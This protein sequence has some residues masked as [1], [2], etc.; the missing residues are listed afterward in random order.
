VGVSVVNALSRHL[1][2]EVAR[3]R[4]LYRQEFS[5]GLATTALV[6]HGAAPNRRG[7]TI[8]FAPDPQIFGDELKLDPDRVYRL[9]RS[10]AYLFAGVEVRWRCAAELLGP[11]SA[12]PAQ[13]SMVFPGG[14][15]DY[16]RER[17]DG[18]DLVGGRPF[19]GTARLADDGSRLDWAIAWPD[20]GSGF[21]QSYC[22]TIPTPLGGTH[23]SGLRMG[24][25]RGLR[26]FADLTGQKRA[27]VITADDVMASGAV[28]LSLFLP[29]PQFQ[30]QTKERLTSTQATRLVESA[31][32]DNFEHWLS[33]DPAA[34]STLLA[35]ILDTA[36]ERIRRRS[37]RETERK[38]A[39]RRLRLPGKLADCA[40]AGS[41]GTEIFLVE[42]DSA[43][44]TA[45]TARQRETQAILPLRGKIMNV[46][47]ASAEK[48]A[49]N[50]E[51]GNLALALG[52]GTRGQCDPARLRYERVI[53]MTDADVDGAHIAS[54]LITYFHRE[55]RPI[56]RDGHLF[57]AQPPLYRLARGGHVRYARDDAHR[58]ALLA[59]EF[60]GSGKVDI[61]R[62][63]GL[64][65]MSAAQLKAT[66][67]DPAVR[68][69]L[70]VELVDPPAPSDE[71]PLI[72]RLMGRNP[73]PRLRF[74]QEHAGSI[75]DLDI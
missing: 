72:E 2:V 8:T 17:L 29:D 36:E 54:L 15:A 64:G 33:A 14:L 60:S 10:K 69:L 27:S 1:E 31:I 38:S 50:Q 41:A 5:R 52:C 16:L 39:T 58:D 32:K 48:L 63:K 75:D 47:S 57:L 43:G 74:I 35:A 9:V 6:E 40:R 46:A 13:A 3:D 19:C 61:S 71:P 49:G 26:S 62:F 70:R 73:E 30:G 68:T 67:M 56:V 34:G 23:E 66:T 12:T 18:Q 4:K 55:M 22:N 44:G 45:K 21:A 25:V 11:Q 65:E 51:I 53:I 42:G 59:S 28:L 7:T 20:G 24:L 37:A